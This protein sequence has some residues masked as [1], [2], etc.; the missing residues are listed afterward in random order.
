MLEQ[1]IVFAVVAAAV[2]W[3]GLRAAA[4]LK[5]GGD[6]CGGGCASCPSAG[7]ECAPRSQGEGRRLPEGR[8]ALRVVR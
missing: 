6:G 4:A 1:G 3:A 7:G 2:A 8:R 5:G